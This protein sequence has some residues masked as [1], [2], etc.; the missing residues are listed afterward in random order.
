MTDVLRGRPRSTGPPSPSEP[1]PSVVVHGALGALVA[2]L[3]GL[4]V[5]AAVVLIAWVA[6]ARSGSSGADAVRAGADAWLL[7]HGGGLSLPGGRVAG[8]PLGL[9]LLAAGVL[10]RA[11]ASLARAVE[12]ADL[13]AA[14]RAVGALAVVYGLATAAVARI[15]ATPEVAVNAVLS[16]LGA[17]LLAGLAGGLG[18]VRGAGLT[19]R[20]RA[21]LPARVPAVAVAA[22]AAVL[23][24]IGAGLLLVLVSVGVHA[25]RAGELAGALDA[26][27]VGTVVLV[28]GC[29]LLL[30]NAALWATAYAAGPGFAVGVGT[31]VSP[32]SVVL[33]PVPAFPLLAALPQDGTPP[34]AV[35]AVLLLPVLAGVVAGVVLVRALPVE[36]A[37][38]SLPRMV[39]TAGWGLAAGL[40]AAATLA[41]LAALA[42]GRLGDGYLA[43]VGPSPWRVLL[44]LALEIGAPAAVTAAL[45]PTREDRTSRGATLDPPASRPPATATPPTKPT[46]PPTKPTR[47]SA[48]PARPSAEPA[49]P[50]AEPARSLAEPTRPSAERTTTAKPPRPHAA[51]TR[52]GD[53]P[54]TAIKPARPSA[55]HARS[56]AGRGVAAEPTRA[57]AESRAAADPTRTPAEPEEGARSTRPSV[58]PA[59]PS[60]ESARPSAGAGSGA[61]EGAGS[62]PEGAEAE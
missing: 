57:S 54:G 16:G 18:V 34:P 15:A 58:T 52:S 50:S 11:G 60:A 30:P 31:G 6:D 23:G 29:V 1:A 51:P 48:K 39:R 36:P 24:L 53:E 19:D 3:S 2:A 7:A 26:G 28:I 10:H 61:R 33:G 59:R 37:S 56:P 49:R 46:R 44:A 8:V 14:A 47:P 35:R 55:G 4:A 9:T 43:A 25:G 22:G 40:A 41:L 21:A 13:R 42:G 38:G 17:T 20:L 62:G 12:V 5:L 27:L 45:L 32:F